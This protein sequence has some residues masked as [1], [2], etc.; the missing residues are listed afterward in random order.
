MPQRVA[1][2]SQLT[3]DLRPTRAGAERRQ[4]ALFIEVDQAVHPRQRHRHHWPLRIRWIDVAGHRCAAAI[5]DQAQVLFMGER[6]QLAD[7]LGGLGKGH[8][9]GIIAQRTFAQRQPVRQ[10]L[11]P[12]M[13]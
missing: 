13:Q 4:Q 3:F 9:I 2:R 1:F 6:Q 12:R 7:V 10:A 11:S 8:R 5:R